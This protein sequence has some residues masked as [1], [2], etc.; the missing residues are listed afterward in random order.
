[1]NN[2]KPEHLQTTRPDAALVGKLLKAWGLRELPGGAQLP[3]RGPDEDLGEG[4]HI[5]ADPAVLLGPS[6][7]G[8]SWT[9][10]L[11]HHGSGYAYHKGT[12]LWLCLHGCRVAVYWHRSLARRS[13]GVVRPALRARAFVFELRDGRRCYW[14]IYGE[15]QQAI[16]HLRERLEHAGYIGDDRCRGATV[17]GHVPITWLSRLPSLRDGVGVTVFRGRATRGPHAGKSV[18]TVKFCS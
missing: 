12:P 7:W 4:T 10:C 13:G 18:Y 5:T 9:S 2:P 3:A 17:V 16:N 11:R 6:E 15:S 14:R 1:M 8:T